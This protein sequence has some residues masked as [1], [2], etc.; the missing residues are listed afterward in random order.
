MLECREE[1]ADSGKNECLYEHYGA[2][3][4]A[5][6]SFLSNGTDSVQYKE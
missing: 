5:K 4:L 1:D 2:N 3:Q 6:S